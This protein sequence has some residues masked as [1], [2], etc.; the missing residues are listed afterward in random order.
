MDALLRRAVLEE[1]AFYAKYDPAKMEMRARTRGSY[2]ARWSKKNAAFY[3]PRQTS[4]N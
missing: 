2:L 3:S 4:G 1:A